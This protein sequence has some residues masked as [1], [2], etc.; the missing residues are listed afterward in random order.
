M[1]ETSR[2]TR[3]TPTAQLSRRRGGSTGTNDKPNDADGAT[4]RGESI[5]RAYEQLRQLIVS[6][7]LAAGSRVVEAEISER[8]GVSRTPARSAIHR[9]Q[10]EGYITLG[11]RSKDRRL[12]VAPLTQGDAREL[13]EIVGQLEGLAAR[14]AAA[15]ERAKRTPV[16]QQLRRL[17]SEL[18]TTARRRRPD[19]IAIFDLDMAFH[20]CYVE[21]GAGPRLLGLH[22]AT[23]PQA[24]RYVRIYITS[25]IDEIATSVE[26]HN[27]I[28]RA[29]DAGDPLAAQQ[30]VDTNWR[31]AAQ[32]LSRVI[33]SLG[34]RGSW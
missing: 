15:L 11:E 24:E 2:K 10:Q 19:P 33:D 28:V 22:D 9:L 20:R 27:A 21:A 6:G 34:E 17:N 23:K 13:F 29:I 30:A 5:A 14:G 18:G 32:R 4:G 26:E 16:V 8:L 31:N 12:I 1:A 7:R 25:L 3:S